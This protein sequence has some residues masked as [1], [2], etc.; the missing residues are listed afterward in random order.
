MGGKKPNNFVITYRQMSPGIGGLSNAVLSNANAFHSRIIEDGLG[1]LF[2]FGWEAVHVFVLLSGFSLALSLTK[3]STRPH[4]T[5]WIWTRA[6]RVLIPFYTISLPL[7]LVMLMLSLYNG[8]GVLGQF[9]RKLA[10]NGGESPER[11]ILSQLLLEDP[12]H[13]LWVPTFLAPAWWFVPAILFGYLFFPAIWLA[14]NR[15]GARLTLT[16]SLAVSI[17]SYTLMLHWRIIEWGWYFVIPNE[18]FNFSLGAVLGRYFGSTQGTKKIEACLR[19]PRSLVYGVLLVVVGNLANLYSATYPVSSSIF[20]LGLSMCGGY[21]AVLLGQTWLGR[22]IGAIDSYV[23]YLSHQPFAFVFAVLCMRAHMP[24]IP[25][26]GA[27][28]YISFALL[29]ARALGPAVEWLYN[30][31]HRRETP[32]VKGQTT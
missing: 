5:S 32:V 12:W 21:L 20:T 18:A 24:E 11:V 2:E 6:E 1:V 13:R 8:T 30:L 10:L 31:A 16:L 4:W 28:L 19:S 29:L 7:T 3:R 9:A 27:I 15:C 25:A 26:L 14:L 23:L 17:L 22:I